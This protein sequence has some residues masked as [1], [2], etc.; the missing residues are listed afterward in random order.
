MVMT[1]AAAGVNRAPLGAR[2]QVILFSHTQP[3]G[4]GAGD[5]E[6]NA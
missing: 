1:L 4:R 3:S 6:S 2:M 5:R